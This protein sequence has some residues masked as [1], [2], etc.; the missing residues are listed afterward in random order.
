MEQKIILLTEIFLANN[1]MFTITNPTKV[2]AI[3][4]VVFLLF[5]MIGFITKSISFFL[6]GLLIFIVGCIIYNQIHENYMNHDPKLKDLREILEDF[7][8]SKTNWK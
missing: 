1:K 5:F 7:F 6:A 2:I 8:E 3:L 4:C